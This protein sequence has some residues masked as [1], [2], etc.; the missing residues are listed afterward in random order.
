[1]FGR[2]LVRQCFRRTDGRVR[3]Y[4]LRRPPPQRYA[5]RFRL[6]T[7]NFEPAANAVRSGLR[8]GY[9]KVDSV[10]RRPDVW[11]RFAVDNADQGIA[12]GDVIYAPRYHHRGLLPEQSLS[13]RQP[14][15]TRSAI[16]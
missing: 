9:R 5:G 12:T 10:V 16:R 13:I 7:P 6:R 1:T 2:R 4:A 3:L 15:A 8:G 11:S 14:H